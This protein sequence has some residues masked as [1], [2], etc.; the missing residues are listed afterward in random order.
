MRLDGLTAA[1]VIRLLDPQAPSEGSHYPETFRDPA[2]P[3]GRASR[4]AIYYLL[5]A[6]ETSGVASRRRRRDLAPLCWRA[7]GHHHVSPS[8]LRRLRPSSR[9]RAR[10]RAAA[11]RNSLV[12]AGWWQARP[13]SAPGRWSAA[14]SRQVSNSKV[15]RWRRRAGD[16]HR[17]NHPGD[18]MPTKRKIANSCSAAS[19]ASSMPQPA[20][21]T[22][23]V[24]DWIYT[25]PT[26]IPGQGNSATPL[27]Y[28]AELDARM[29]DLIEALPRRQAHSHPI[30]LTPLVADAARGG[31]GRAGLQVKDR[32]FGRSRRL[33]ACRLPRSRNCRSR[34]GR[35]RMDGRCR[36]SERQQNQYRQSPGRSSKVRLPAAFASWLV[37]G[38]RSPS[39]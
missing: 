3:R 16:R 24:G 10:R 22:L 33:P 25:S 21:S 29:L 8:G 1:E 11:N 35:A 7:A 9:H 20:L 26:A 17:A 13:R 18:R 30:R 12:P 34:R 5:D 2:G 23:I 6:G 15:S 32:S 38:R 4:P 28:S 19:G 39:A 36:R 37:E 27:S 14:R 31:S